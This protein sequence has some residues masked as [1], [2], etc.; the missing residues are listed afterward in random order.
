MLIKKYKNML[1][2]IKNYRPFYYF[3]TP[4]RLNLLDKST[5]IKIN[6]QSYYKIK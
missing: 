6:G 3:N 5:L 4:S 2:S 1:D